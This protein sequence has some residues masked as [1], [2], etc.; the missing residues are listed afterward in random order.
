MLPPI[1]SILSYKHFIAFL[2][3]S[4]LVYTDTLAT[5]LANSGNDSATVDNT[6]TPYQVKIKLPHQFIERV[7]HAGIALLD[8]MRLVGCEQA[9]F[10]TSPVQADTFVAECDHPPTALIINGFQTIHYFK[11]EA[12]TM[13]FAPEKLI[14][15]VPIA[16]NQTYYFDNARLHQTR[17][18]VDKQTLPLSYQDIGQDL[19]FRLP[20]S[21]HCDRIKQISMAEV[22]QNQRTLVFEQNA[23]PCSKT[24]LNH[25]EDYAIYQFP[26]QTA[27]R[28]G[29]NPTQL[30]RYTEAALQTITFTPDTYLKLFD[31]L[32][33]KAASRCTQTIKQDE[34]WQ[35]NF[36]PYDCHGKRQLIV[37]STGEQLDQYGK[38]IPQTLLKVFEKQLESRIPFTLVSIQ[39]GRKLSEPLLRCEDLADL[40][41]SKARRFIWQ[42]LKNIRFGA[43]DLRALQDLDLVNA[44]Y[45]KA[46][47]HNVLY[48]T[49]NSGLPVDIEHINDKDLSVPLITWKKAGIPLNV[50][51]TAS[52]SPWL[53]K[54]EARCQALDSEKAI[55]QIQRA[56]TDFLEAESS[57]DKR[58][59]R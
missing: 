47:L 42:R 29:L 12:Q 48:L 26:N 43:R 54:A 8:N 20:S 23:K 52:C 41:A 3:I 34:H 57:S 32:N 30:G 37:I 49:D 13:I 17:A 6:I 14:T 44:V 25:N 4:G 33:D 19:H 50:L 51:T 24:P 59:K 46:R 21:P 28:E 38:Q 45:T 9:D 53:E 18:V 15:E 11:S 1:H 58:N 39:P 10:K 31:E 27:C 5:S 55:E 35:L 7:S 16:A 2:L 36:K 22:M 56:L 40:E